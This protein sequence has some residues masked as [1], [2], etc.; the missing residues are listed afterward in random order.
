MKSRVIIHCFVEK[1]DIGEFMERVHDIAQ[2]NVEF[3]QRIDRRSGP[4]G[5]RLPPSEAIL[6]ALQERSL[7]PK[8]L[9]SLLR[10]K[11]SSLSYHLSVLRKT[12]RVVKTKEGAYTL[13]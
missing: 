4:K 1:S 11:P 8:E 10:L 7:K 9:G 3:A 2:M 12:K 5:K 13:P 6:L